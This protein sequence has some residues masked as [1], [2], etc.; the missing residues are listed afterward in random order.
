MDRP[1][2][3][4]LA[5]PRFSKINTGTSESTT[6]S[7]RSNDGFQPRFRPDNRVVDPPP[8]EFAEQRAVLG[9]GR[10]AEFG[11][12]PELMVVGQGGRKGVEKSPGQFHV[13]RGEPVVSLGHKQQ[14]ALGR[15]GLAER[16][17]KHVAI[18][19]LGKKE[20]QGVGR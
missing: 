10:I 17:G 15:G 11:K 14:R 18:N 12:F 19:P 1:G 4:F 6:S 3:E 20:L 5:S 16:P 7:I 9:F 8:A 2:D 13:L